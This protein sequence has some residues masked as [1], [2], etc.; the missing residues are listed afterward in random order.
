M[1]KTLP[2]LL[3]HR[4]NGANTGLGYLEV[5]MLLSMKIYY[6]AQMQQSLKMYRKA[7]KPR[8]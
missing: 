7:Q 2:P 1:F 5:K 4:Y 8:A 6:K 3:V